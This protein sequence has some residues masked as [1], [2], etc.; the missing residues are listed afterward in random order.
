MYKESAGWRLRL[1]SVT[2]SPQNTC[3]PI[4]Q[5]AA[6]LCHCRRTAGAAAR[7]E[8]LGG[9]EAAARVEEL[10]ART[11]ALTAEHTAGVAVRTEELGVEKLRHECRTLRVRTSQMLRVRWLCIRVRLR[12]DALR[13][14][15]LSKRNDDKQR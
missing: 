11:V 3:N 7:T 6:E 14:G 1:S 9:R 12:A 2:R 13:F 8:E 15:R 4:T 10:G 5:T